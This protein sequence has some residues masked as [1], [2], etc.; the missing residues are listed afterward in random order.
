MQRLS[1]KAPLFL[2]VNYLNNVYVRIQL[3][4]YANLYADS[5][6]NVFYR[7]F[8]TKPVQDYAFQTVIFGVNLW[9]FTNT[10]LFC[11]IIT[12]NLIVFYFEYYIRNFH[13]RKIIQKDTIDRIYFEIENSFSLRRNFILN[14]KKYKRNIDWPEVFADTTLKFEFSVAS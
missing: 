1:Y 4:Y 6:F 10:W 13:S 7:D 11:Y 3:W 8:S 5:R 9:D 2:L 12:F 14:K